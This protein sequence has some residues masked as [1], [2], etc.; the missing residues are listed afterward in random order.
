[1]F[2]NVAVHPGEHCR[3]QAI[4]VWSDRFKRTVSKTRMGLSQ[5]IKVM[6]LPLGTVLFPSRM[7][8]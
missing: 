4:K 7:H 2:E 8:C 6:T 1:M 3:R 5:N